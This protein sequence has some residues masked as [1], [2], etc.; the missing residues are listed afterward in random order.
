LARDRGDEES[1]GAFASTEEQEAPQR[2]ES[3]TGDSTDSQA[4]E[5]DLISNVP[6]TTTE[7]ENHEHDRPTQDP[8]SDS[9]PNFI[10]CRWP[11]LR[12]TGRN[13]VILDD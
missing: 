7:P 11:P 9:S 2:V 3:R 6:A 5:P 1:T 10:F 4:V 13:W 12:R 8:S